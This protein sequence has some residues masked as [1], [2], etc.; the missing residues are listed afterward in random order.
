M[1]TPLANKGIK[2]L[3]RYDLIQNKC[4]APWTFFSYRHINIGMAYNT[5]PAFV[6]MLNIGMAYNTLPVFE[7]MPNIGMAYNTLSVFVGMP[8]AVRKSSDKRP[9]FF[10][11]SFVSNSFP[12]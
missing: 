5:L 1:M 9:G 12:S 8:N 10:S 6:G 3:R 4:F 7:C 2:K 11:R